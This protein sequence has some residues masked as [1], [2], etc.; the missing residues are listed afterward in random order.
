MSDMPSQPESQSPRKPGR[1]KMP[2]L[3]Q[4][5]AFVASFALCA[6]LPLLVM[7]K[8]FI[9]P[10]PNYGVLTYFVYILVAWGVL[11]VVGVGFY[12]AKRAEV[13]R[14]IV[15]GT[16]AGAIIGFSICSGVLM[17]GK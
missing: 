1:T 16:L 14:G 4:N 15:L 11:L 8:E 3:R 6:L 10:T 17:M 9:S 12:L 5:R 13:G 7:T 2:P